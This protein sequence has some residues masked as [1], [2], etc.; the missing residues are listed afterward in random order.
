[1]NHAVLV[2][3]AGDVG[4]RAAVLLAGAGFD[5]FALRRHVPRE[6]HPG[7]RWLAG[8]L[9]RPETLQGLP[10][11]RHV[12]YCATPAG[13]DDAAYRAIFLDGP[14]HLLSAL[15]EPPQRMVFASSSA[16]YGEHGGA[17]VDESTPPAPLGFNGRVLL[18]AEAA[19]RDAVS[20]AVAVRLAGLYGPGRLQLIQRLRDGQAR[21]PRGQGVYANRIHVQDAAASLV[22]LA[23]LEQPQPVYVAVDDR[24]RPIDELYDALARLAGAVPPGDGPPPPGVGN[25]RL[26]NARLK[27]TGFVL[28]W[29]DAAD[30]YAACLS[31]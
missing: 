1:M 3:G 4:T 28:Q 24:P 22:H 29:P 12:I 8:D 16:V 5:V 11:V 14:R 15:P 27:A 18:E 31:P 26:S 20:E 21:V 2:A 25:K 19:L 9:T 30:G 17:W 7:V 13:R 10:S 6:A 23:C